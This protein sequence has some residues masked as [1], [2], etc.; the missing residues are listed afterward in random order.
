MQRSLA[1]AKGNPLIKPMT[2]LSELGKDICLHAYRDSL[3]LWKKKSEK[4]WKPVFHTF[5]KSLAAG[6]RR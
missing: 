2:V 3:M 4:I 5:E 1:A 6:G